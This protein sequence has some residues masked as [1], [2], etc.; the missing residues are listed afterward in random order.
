[1]PGLHPLVA[2][3]LPRSPAPRQLPA[4]NARSRPPNTSARPLAGLNGK[5]CRGKHARET[6]VAHRKRDINVRL[7]VESPT[8]LSARLHD[9]LQTSSAFQLARLRTALPRPLEAQMGFPP[10]AAPWPPGPTSARRRRLCP[11]RRGCEV[12]GCAVQADRR[13]FPL[14]ESHRGRG[15]EGTEVQPRALGFHRG[16]HGEER[17]K[18]PRMGPG[19]HR[20]PGQ[21]RLVPGD[22][23]RLGRHLPRAREA[24]RPGAPLL[25]RLQL[26]RTAGRGHACRRSP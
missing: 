23:L 7:G 3:T 25:P 26:A 16:H 18:D 12:G 9:A 21:T 2:P 13:A 4:E 20:S 6:A 10:R 15:R 11:A 5:T 24:A 14:E 8:K 17:S 19:A 1:M 22:D